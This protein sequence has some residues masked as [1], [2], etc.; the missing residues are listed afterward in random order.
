MCTFCLCL[1]FYPSTKDLVYYLSLA[2]RIW[3][4][5]HHFLLFFLFFKNVRSV[6]RHKMPSTVLSCVHLF[7]LTHHCSPFEYT[8]SLIIMSGPCQTALH[9]ATKRETQEWPKAW[10]PSWLK[11]K[12]KMHSVQKG[13][14]PQLAVSHH[15]RKFFLLHHYEAFHLKA[16]LSPLASPPHIKRNSHWGHVWSG[17]L[18]HNWPS[19]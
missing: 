3:F 4:S 16:E 12:K 9:A 19:L 8:H 5:C 13:S 1:L 6:W 17:P 11:K 2:R 14:F 10:R 15:F 7:S 18:R